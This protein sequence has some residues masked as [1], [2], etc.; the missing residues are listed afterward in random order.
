ML[1]PRPRSHGWFRTWPLLRSK[2]NYKQL[3]I[4]KKNSEHLLLKLSCDGRCRCHGDKGQ[5][6]LHSAK[7]GKSQWRPAREQSV[8][9]RM[10]LCT[11]LYHLCHVHSITS[12]SNDFRI[13]SWE[14]GPAAGS[15]RRPGPREQSGW[16]LQGAGR[17]T[18]GVHCPSRNTGSARG[19]P[20]IPPREVLGQGA[21]LREWLRE[22]ARSRGPEAGCGGCLSSSRGAREGERPGLSH[23]LGDHA[24]SAPGFTR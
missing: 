22:L 6:D 16:G 14:T 2:K 4:F 17:S 23:S 12:G 11:R 15:R 3:Q 24:D 5:T 13:P 18:G 10:S 7:K 1:V 21:R 9:E 8:E 19:F 20:I